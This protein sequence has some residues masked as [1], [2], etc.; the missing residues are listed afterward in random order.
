[1][2]GHINRNYYR[3]LSKSHFL[4]FSHYF[5][6][7]KGIFFQNTQLGNLCDSTNRR[8]YSA[9]PP[10]LIPS[11]ILNYLY[12][13]IF[14]LDLLFYST[15]LPTLAHFVILCDI[16]FLFNWTFYF[17]MNT[18]FGTNA[19]DFTTLYYIYWL[20]LQYFTQLKWLHQFHPFLISPMSAVTSECLSLSITTLSINNS[21][22][23]IEVKL[24]MQL[25]TESITKCGVVLNAYG[26]H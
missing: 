12:P 23:N 14:F 15:L 17:I 18:S 5:F 3:T 26:L 13:F 7:L 19:T 4:S 24:R 8:F 21:S 20:I 25:H 2:M 1:M 16:Q 9:V 22:G 6:V 11:F 10:S